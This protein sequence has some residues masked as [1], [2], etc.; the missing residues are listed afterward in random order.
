MK[1]RWTTRN[2][3]APVLPPSRRIYECYATPF[4]ILSIFEFMLDLVDLQS[5]EPLARRAASIRC[6]SDYIVGG[7]GDEWTLAEH[8]ASWS[9]I[10]LL[11]RMLRGVGNR[12]PETTVLGT[13]VSFPAF[14]SADG[15]P[16]LVSRRCRSGNRSGCRRRKERSSVRARCP[17]WRASKP[18][19]RRRADHDGFNCTSITAIAGS[20]EA[21]SNALRRPD[22]PALCL[23]VDATRRSPRNHERDKAYPRFACRVIYNWAT[24]RRIIPTSITRAREKARRSRNTSIRSGTRRSRGRNVEWPRSIAPMPVVVKG[25]PRSVRREARGRP[26]RC[27]RHGVEIHGGRQLDLRFQRRSRCFR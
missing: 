20:H 21:S 15:L 24:S 19:R 9:R 4:S 7:A 18:S 17:T 27:R 5:L 8:V 25:V 22:V 10:Q 11:P 6:C 14:G 13:P 3:Q 12:S 2:S 23:T 1:A 16:R 26:W